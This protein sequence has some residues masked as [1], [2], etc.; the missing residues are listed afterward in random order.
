ME[1]DNP[2]N[3]YCDRGKKEKSFLFSATMYII[4]S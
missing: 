3:E 2:K 4:A 1:D